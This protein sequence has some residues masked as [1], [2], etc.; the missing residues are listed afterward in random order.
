VITGDQLETILAFVLPGFIA[1]KIFAKRGG[2]ARRTDLEWTL[3]SVLVAYVIGV[4][5][6]LAGLGRESSERFV[7]SLLMGAAVGGGGVLA[8]WLWHGM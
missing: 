6:D 4:A 2:E 7:P 8:W 5:L 1:L 3:W